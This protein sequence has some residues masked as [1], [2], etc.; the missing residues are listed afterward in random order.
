MSNNTSASPASPEPSGCPVS[1]NKGNIPANYN[2][3]AQKVDPKNFMP[4]LNQEP[5][6]GQRIPLSTDRMQ[7]T[8]PKGGADT[9]WVYPSPQMFYN[10]LRRKGK[11]DGDVKEEDLDLVVAIHNQNNEVTWNEVKKWEKTLHCECE[12]KL[13]RF[14][15]R[16]YDLS[17]KARI[18]AWL[19]YELPYDRHDWVVDRCGTEVRY[20]I[21]FYHNEN[22][23]PNEPRLTVDARPAVDTAG[24]FYDRMNMF[25][26]RSFFS[27]DLSSLPSPNAN[28]SIVTPSHVHN[29]S[30]LK[31]GGVGLLSTKE[32]EGAGAGASAGNNAPSSGGCP[33]KH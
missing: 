20:I 7:S 17:P 23:K 8:I 18:K 28:A 2:V 31:Q 5:A 26:R 24:S 19:G 6:P 32:G 33:V 3:Y 27:S 4:T 9:T 25:F 13:V 29:L 12:P 15:G 16:P 10:A 22:P 30:T 21:D 1:H 14:R 11:L